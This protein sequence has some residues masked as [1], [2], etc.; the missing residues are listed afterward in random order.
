MACTIPFVVVV[1]YVLQKFYLLTSRQLRYLDLEARSSLYTH[2]LE[3]L[4]GLASIRAMGWQDASLAINTTYLD[5]GQRPYY[6]LYCI[7]RWLN[8]VLDL[9]V[10]IVAVSVVAMAVKIHGSTSGAAIG[11]ALINILGFT[12]SLSTLVDAFTQLET[13]LGAIARLKSFESD[14]ASENLPRET[15]IPPA[16][17]PDKGRIEFSGVTAAYE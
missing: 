3:T 13:S 11:I 12:Q 1:V 15:E 17:W 16:N 9:L 8:L 14:V 4:D 10:A 6:L 7:Q 2:F 5:L